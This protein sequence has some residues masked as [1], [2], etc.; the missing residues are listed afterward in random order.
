MGGE[1][2]RVVEVFKS[3]QGEGPDAGKPTTFIR[4]FGC[5]RKCPFCDSVF[6][7][8]GKYTEMT[9]EELFDKVK[10]MNEGNE[11]IRICI[12]GGEPLLQYKQITEFF[13]EIHWNGGDEIYY[14]S[15]ET[16][17]D[18]LKGK[19]KKEVADW[20]HY[21]SLDKIIVS[22]KSYETYKRI[23][24]YIE[25]CTFPPEPLHLKI[26]YDGGLKYLPK[27]FERII[28]SLKQLEGFRAFIYIMPLTTGNARIDRKIKQKTWE[29]C[30]KYNYKYSPRLQVDVWGVKKRGV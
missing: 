12:T 11:V 27:D 18:L 7:R 3:I 10:E 26:I 29:F 20:Y 2:L 4:L 25:K 30:V 6:A 5:N 28:E 14:V 17:G 9:A 19:I 16:N 22:P 24:T 21:F 13:K 15:I 1:H 8:K 23:L